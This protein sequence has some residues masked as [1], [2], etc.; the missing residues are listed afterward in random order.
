[1]ETIR[2]PTYSK[3]A[4]IYDTLMKNVDYD[5]WSDFIDEIIQVH[6]PNPQTIL[7]LACGT[8]SLSLALEKLH[9]YQ[10]TATD[11]SAAMVEEAR[12]KAAQK[13]ASI[14]LKQ[15]D[16][17]DIEL[18]ETFDIIVSIFDSINYLH[19]EKE[20]HCMLD[21]LK[22]VMDVQSLFIFDFTT[23]RNSRQAIQYLNKEETLAPDNYRFFQK[24][25]YDAEQQI[26]YNTFKIEQ[27]ADDGAT[28]VRRF[29]E[30]H[31]QRA[32]SL[33]QMQNIIAQTDFEIIA[34][35]EEFDL[36]PAS[37]NSLRITMILQCPHIPS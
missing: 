19:T 3:L 6:H 4:A 7:E 12:R 17:L 8:G 24:N 34:A 2:K 25:R 16:F 18:D 13:E 23:P 5:A 9:C 20:I 35:Y 26:H 33:Q 10:I 31:R 27:L 15:M 28:V 37:E 1:M 30:E 22:K 32:Y 36:K 21:Q 29:S 14:T 11:K